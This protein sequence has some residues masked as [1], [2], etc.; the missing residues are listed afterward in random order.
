MISGKDVVAKRY[1]K[2]L[3][4]LYYILLNQRCFTS[5]LNLEAFFKKNKQLI[6]YLTIPTLSD[7]VKI[8]VME[9]IFQRLGTCKTI[10]RLVRALLRHRRIELLVD[11]IRNIICEYRIRRNM[12]EFKV[13]SSH[14]LS[15]EQQKSIINFLHAKTDA[16]ITAHFEVDPELLCGLRIQGKTFLWERSLS[17]CLKSVER[18]ALRQVGLW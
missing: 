16:S 15:D 14:H 11:V 13:I 8:D 6:V 3:L 10:M 12:M 9:K 4:N 1:A 5:M 18:S 7:E 2:A 17:K